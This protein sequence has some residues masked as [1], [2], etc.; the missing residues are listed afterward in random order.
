MLPKRLFTGSSTKNI[1][2]RASRRVWTR[3][4]L[5]KNKRVKFEVAARRRQEKEERKAVNR[6]LAR[7]SQPGKPADRVDTSTIQERRK[8]EKAK[9]QQQ[10]KEEQKKETKKKSS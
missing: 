8:M 7:A 2:D 5:Q 9:L 1:S 3:L 4:H 10:A 6:A